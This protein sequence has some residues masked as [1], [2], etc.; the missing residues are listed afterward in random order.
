MRQGGRLDQTGRREYRV[1][2]ALLGTL[3]NIALAGIG[4]AASGNAP[5]ILF[6]EQI[7]KSSLSAFLAFRVAARS[8]GTVYIRF[9]LRSLA[10]PLRTFELLRESVPETL[11][12][13]L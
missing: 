9:R 12:E 3:P 10:Y 5:W 2:N 11:A 13:E 6:T 4:N 1:V 7:G 8:A